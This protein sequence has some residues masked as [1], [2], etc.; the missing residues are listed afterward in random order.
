MEKT[1]EEINNHWEE[2]GR[3]SGKKKVGY[4]VDIGILESFLKETKANNV[5]PSQVIQAAMYSYSRGHV[6]VL[7]MSLQWKNIVDLRHQDVSR[8]TH[9]TYTPSKVGRPPIIKKEDAPPK[10]TVIH[11]KPYRKEDGTWVNWLDLDHSTFELKD[12]DV[13]EN[14]SIGADGRDFL[15]IDWSRTADSGSLENM[16]I[17]EYTAYRSKFTDR[18]WEVEYWNFCYLCACK[19]RTQ[20]GMPAL[21]YD[22]DHL[23]AHLLRIKDSCEGWYQTILEGQEAYDR[24]H[25]VKNENP[26]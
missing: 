17:N 25:G 5:T 1:K 24:E 23:Q 22:Q 18:Q 4:A 8:D 3:V 7:G 11:K 14:M 12:F 2:E 10:D 21:R 16:L 19:F 6:G 26:K 15:E 20:N 9:N 13:Y